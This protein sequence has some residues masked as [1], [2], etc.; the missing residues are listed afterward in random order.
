M[1]GGFHL[2]RDIAQ[3]GAMLLMVRLLT[4]EDYGSAALAQSFIGLL[5]VVSFGIFS[6]HTL[7]LREPADID[8]QAHF[9]AAV[10]INCLLF[11][12]TLVAAWLLS[13]TQRYEAAALP[14]AGFALT[15]LVEIPGTLRHR[16]L[17]TQHDWVRFRLLLIMGTVLGVGVGLAIAFLGGGVWALVVQPPLFGLPAA[18][19]LFWRGNWRPDF[20]WSWTRYRDTAFFGINRMGSA[21]AFRGREGV[22]QTVMATA[23]DFAAL[24]VFTRAMGLATLVAGRIG[25]VA[26]QALYPVVTRAE[27][28]SE[29]FQR[30][31]G[32]VLQGVCWTS[33]PAAAFFALNAN[34]TV[35]LLYGQE[36]LSVAPLL[37][38]AVMGVAFNGIA[39]TLSSLLLA[40]DEARL[41]LIID[42]TGA[43]IAVGLA[44][45]LVPTSI[46]TYLAA[47]AMLGLAILMVLLAALAKTNGVSGKGIKAAFL[48]SI[49]ACSV[50]SVTT[51]V[52]GYLAEGSYPMVV[53]LIIGAGVF[54]GV[55]ILV[56]RVAFASSMRAL[57]EIAPGAQQLMR[58]LQFSHP[59]HDLKES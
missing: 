56:L 44:L 23:Y 42:I 14:L 41:C 34:E 18:I 31:A 4:P 47:L 2:L 35:S 55:Y 49:V 39:A 27:I 13:S 21:A 25:S 29:K 3:F 15:F 58:W 33:I 17:E 54:A 22:Q 26:M 1:G 52:G 12:L 32:L 48:P 28:R 10:V 51:E 53:Q 8:W 20:S 24:G 11:L 40:N 43:M 5:S 50:A 19:D 6:A 36:W 16:M 59:D 9:S 38:L 7:Q 37:P 57:I 45:L 30:M 46:I